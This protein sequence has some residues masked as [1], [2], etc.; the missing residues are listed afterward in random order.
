MYYV[1]DGVAGNYDKGVWED[2]V[3]LCREEEGW[4]AE[5]ES[6]RLSSFPSGW[7]IPEV[8]ANFKMTPSANIIRRD[9]QDST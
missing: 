2:A 5:R 6:N 4:Q 8:L 9:S 7:F 1:Y 3:E